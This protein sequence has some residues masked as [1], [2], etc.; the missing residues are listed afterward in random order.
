[1]S[2]QVVQTQGLNFSDSRES[3][4]VHNFRE[5]HEFG[6]RA[7]AP[8]L[9][10]AQ[11]DLAAYL[12]DQWNQQEKQ[13]LE[14]QRR[15]A[16]VFNRIRR[17]IKMVTGFERRSRHSIVAE[18]VGNED[19][20]TASQLS[21][22][23]LWIMNQNRM[24]HTQSDAFEG[25]LKTGINLLQ[26]S[27]DYT[28]DPLDGD[29]KLA[30]VPYNQFLLDPRMQNR[31][32]SDCEFIIQRRLLSR[33]AVK[34]L[35]P[36]RSDD[37]D[38]LKGNTRD[39]KFPTMADAVYRTSQE[40]LRY[41]EFW[42]RTMK[43]ERQL[44]NKQTG[45]IVP[46]QRGK[47]Q[48]AKEFS[49]AYRE[50]ELVTRQVPSVNLSILVEEIPMWDG[51]EPWGIGDYPHVPVMAFW[52]PEHTTNN[53]GQITGPPGQDDLSNFFSRTPSGDFSLKLQSLVRCQRDPQTEA[54]KR[55]SKMLDIVDSQI[56][57]GWQAKSGAVANPKDLYQSG[58][59][60][61]I[62][63]KDDAQ[64]TDAVRLNPAD[65]P[66]GLFQL[67]QQ[68]DSDIV[69]IAG[70][71]EELLGMAEDGNLQMSG[72][73]AQ[74]RQGAGITVL[75]D[76]FDNFRLSQRLLG[77]KLIK[78]IQ[79]NFSPEKVARIINE[80]PTQAFYDKKF[81]KFDAVV[82]ESMETPSQR[83][84][85]Y[86]QLIQARELGIPI[87]DETIIDFMPITDK[88]PIRE[89]MAAQKQQADF[90][91]QQ[92]LEDAMRLRELQRAKVF[93]DIGLGVER[94]ARAEADRGLAQ[95]RQSEFAENH[96][97]ATLARAKAVK[98]LEAMDTDR[99]VKLMQ[100][101]RDLENDR[102]AMGEAQIEM[103][104]K[105]GQNDFARLLAQTLLV[106]DQSQ[107][108]QG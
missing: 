29:I 74:L 32:L 80:Q 55:R 61:V 84:L 14:H 48:R 45:E 34:G 15:N 64:M 87:P 97:Q 12:G 7:W 90:I 11:K 50:W 108:A 79:H 92:Q 102:V 17:N 103:D 23:I 6:Y 66:T 25:C 39:G 73:L 46:V 52:D 49:Q 95:E 106:T 3:E 38:L 60:R 19:E 21:G 107:P 28:D 101:A 89:A 82:Q 56:N 68:F 44:I 99:L 41:D 13:T 65:L 24:L 93:S 83:A 51:E 26:L 77:S 96:A 22:V 88:E 40:S 75:Q 35:L 105:Q 18:P 58:Q 54:N 20:E 1:M 78:M 104:R 69:E 31:D 36:Q 8:F 72:V 98:E 76:L 2:V 86:T 33:A 71:T 67:S 70:I 91:Q 43:E 53:S 4:I 5:A 63:M 57:T 94:I 42:T 16:L 27:M 9:Q 100:L 62:W 37:I 47:V 10:E 81:G 59:G 30:R 85:A